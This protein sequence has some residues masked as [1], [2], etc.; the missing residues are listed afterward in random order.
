MKKLMMALCVAMLFAPGLAPAVA[1]PNQAPSTMPPY[2]KDK[3]IPIPQITKQ[4]LPNGL[5]VWVVPRKGLPRVDYVLALRGAGYAADDKAHPGFASI[6]AG[7]LNEGTA[8]R[9]SR[10]VAETAQSLGGTVGGGASH[11]GITVFANALASNAGPMMALMAEVARQPA[12]PDREVELA[13]VNALEALKVSE[14]T[15]GFRAERALNKAVHGDHPYGQSAPTAQAINAI[16]QALL[17]REHGRRFRP[18][19]ALLVVTGRITSAQALKLAASAF[20]NW[21]A[22]GTAL[23]ETARAPT[24]AKPVRLVLERPGS[25]QS[26]VRLGSPGIAA[27][28]DDYVPLRLASTVLGGGFT[29]R[30]NLNLREEKGY[31][32]GASAGA[33]SFRQGG[34]IVGGADVRNEVTGASL[35]EYFSEY[36]KLATEL[37]PPE[38]LA[39]NKR[40]VAGTYTLSNQLQ[41]AVAAT[42]ANNWLVG[43]PPEFLGRYVP[44]IQK[45]TAEQ[46]RDVA[47]K[48]FAPE[49]QSI[50]VV[51]DSAAIAEQLKAYGQ[52]TV[53][54]K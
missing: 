31:T 11:D 4:T 52:F 30:I 51:G 54:E 26:T 10:A 43:L 23:A 19:R 1:A 40:Y 22:S 13:K 37:V 25:V 44:A 9:N 36:G 24:T 49:N 15:P 45:V 18:D 7:M 12:F 5:Q 8:K 27:T 42:L 47:R 16:D 48:Y 3:P 17:R 41:G 28:M 53:Q 38:E 34:A 50:V 6:L 33:R 46:V 21:K 20:G 32:Y 35:K 14:A 29:S 2:G 39:M